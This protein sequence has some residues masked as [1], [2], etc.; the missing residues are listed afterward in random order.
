MRETIVKHI[1]KCESS[2]NDVYIGRGSKW[3]N[4]F[5]IG[6]DGTREEVVHKYVC[7]LTESGLENDIFEELSG[8][9]LVCYCAP[10][11]CHGHV[12]KGH[13]EGN[14]FYEDYA[15]DIRVYTKD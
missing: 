12:L 6:R 1:N 4:P 15:D 9:D 7:Y 11:L 13:L 3:G 8:K 2:P 14:P 10:K 5:I